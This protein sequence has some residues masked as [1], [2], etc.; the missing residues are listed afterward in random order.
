MLLSPQIRPGPLAQLVS[1]LSKGVASSSGCRVLGVN[2]PL[3]RHQSF[4]AC[5]RGPSSV[6]GSAWEPG[7]TALGGLLVILGGLRSRNC[8]RRWGIA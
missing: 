7:D 2:A 8:P 6:R 1:E 4:L 5:C 3:V